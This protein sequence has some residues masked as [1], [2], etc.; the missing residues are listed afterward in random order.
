MAI[1]ASIRIIELATSLGLTLQKKQ[2][3]L[4]LA[5]SCTGGLTSAA[6]TDI[7]GSSAW[8]DRGFITYSNTA[9]QEMLGVKEA[10]LVKHGAVSEETALEMALGALK[11]SQA[12][13]AAS[14]TGIAGPSGGSK[15]KPVGTVCFAWVSSAG[16]HNTTRMH[17]NG[18]RQA[19]RQQSVI[20]VITGLLALLKN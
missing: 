4:A 15:S 3:S 8:F 19:V 7:A 18:D 20:S 1:D 12:T 11:N 17:L 5:E 14:I 6:I 9:K 16:I 10:T 2:M 13:I